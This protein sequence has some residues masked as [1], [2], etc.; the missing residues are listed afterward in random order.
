MGLLRSNLLADT[1]LAGDRVNGDRDLGRE[2]AEVLEHR[3]ATGVKHQ[4]QRPEGMIIRRQTGQ[5]I[6]LGLHPPQ[7]AIAPRGPIDARA[8]E[9]LDGVEPGA[10]Q[11]GDG[12]GAKNF[13]PA[14]WG[15]PPGLPTRIPPAASNRA[16]A[17]SRQA[18]VAGPMSIRS[19]A[20]QRSPSLAAATSSAPKGRPSPAS[21]TAGRAAALGAAQAEAEGGGHAAGVGGGQFVAVDAARALV[22]E[23]RQQRGPLGD[24]AE[25]LDLPRRK[26]ARV[27][28]VRATPAAG[29]ERAS[30]PR[31]TAWLMG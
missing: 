4:P 19:Q 21:T 29:I 27:G 14:C 28:G 11:M 17:R 23:P 13:S 31:W 3:R 15:R 5:V 30:R 26:R 18:V 24:F 20:V 8:S 9:L 22:I 2:F 6:G 7:G 12:P 16:I 1:I 25:P 10:A